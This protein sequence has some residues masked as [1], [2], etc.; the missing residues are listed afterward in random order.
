MGSTPISTS[1]I[2]Y[3][4]MLNKLNKALFF[5]P[6]EIL[7]FFDSKTSNFF[8]FGV[9]GWFFQKLS[10]KT[11]FMHSYFH[12]AV[13]TFFSSSFFFNNNV[14]GL[15]RAYLKYF[16]LRGR[17]FRFLFLDNY[18]IIKLGFSHKLYYSIT[19]NIC[20]TLITKQVLK[21]S[22]KSLSKLKTC[23]F[24]LHAI[25]KFDKYKGKGLLYYKDSLLLKS[26]SK[27]TKV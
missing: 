3:P 14:F 16:Q 25:R 1:I 12:S 22:G 20:I 27:K 15:V 13:R 23:F 9:V 21:I 2:S 24:D 5:I 6:P 8:F 4:L 17:S 7:F 11:S 10:Q 18:L 19:H 26:S